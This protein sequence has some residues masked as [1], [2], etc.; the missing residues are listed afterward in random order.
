MDDS[1][2]TMYKVPEKGNDNTIVDRSVEVKRNTELDSLS[3]FIRKSS[4]KMDIY[5]LK[6]IG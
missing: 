4:L 6:S 1:S 2:N 3:K 5:F